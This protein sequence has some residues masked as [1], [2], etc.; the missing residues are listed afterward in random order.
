MAK[1]LVR[2][3]S[4]GWLCTAEASILERQ[5]TLILRLVL[6]RRG[7]I[8]R[9]QILDVLGTPS[10]RFLGWRGFIRAISAVLA[11]YRPWSGHGSARDRQ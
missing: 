5:V 1:E 3:S 8:R 4:R 2:M 6:D 10:A 9:G 11:R 7:R